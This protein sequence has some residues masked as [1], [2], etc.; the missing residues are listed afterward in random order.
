[1]SKSNS[2]PYSNP[3][4]QNTVAVGFVSVSE[5]TIFRLMGEPADLVDVVSHITVTDA[6]SNSV[7]A[8]SEDQLSST[9]VV[10]KKGNYKVCEL[11][12]LKSGE[13]NQ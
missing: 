1:M 11:C 3:H 10:L 12:L 5:P 4:K 7:V 2:H 9:Y 8:R 6:G 13:F